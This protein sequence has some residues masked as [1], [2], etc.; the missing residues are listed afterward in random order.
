MLIKQYNPR[1]LKVI[2][3]ISLDL[4]SPLSTPHD[5]QSSTIIQKKYKWL[6][7]YTEQSLH[8]FETISHKEIVILHQEQIKAVK[9]ETQILQKYNL[10]TP[11][12]T[13]QTIDQY[14]TL[15][16]HE[17][18]Q[19]FYLIQDILTHIQ[20]QEALEQTYI[21]PPPQPSTSTSNSPQPTPNNPSTYKI[22]KQAIRNITWYT[23]EPIPKWALKEP[24][25]TPEY[26]KPT[27][28]QWQI[29]L[30]EDQADVMIVNGSRQ[31]GKSL[32]FKEN[33]LLYNNSYKKSKDLKIW[34]KIMSSNYTSQTITSLTYSKK[35]TYKITLENWIVHEVTGEHRIPT[36]KNFSPTQ[37]TSTNFDSN[38]TSKKENYQTAKQLYNHIFHSPNSKILNELKEKRRKNNSNR[39]NIQRRLQEKLQKEANIFV[40]TAFNYQNPNQTIPNDLKNITEQDIM[41]IWYFIWDWTR[42]KN[43][44]SWNHD[45]LLNLS[46]Q[47]YEITKRNDNW[48]CYQYNIH[49]FKQKIEQKFPDPDFLNSFNGYSYEK[50]ISPLIFTLPKEH[51]WKFLEWLF[52][53]DSYLSSQ[54]TNNKSKSPN[55]EYC[56]TS[57]E[58]IQQLQLFLLQMWIIN[59]TKTR[60]IKSNFKNHRTY[61]YYLYITDKQSLKTLVENID[62]TTKKNYSEF[63]QALQSTTTTNWKNSLIPLEAVKYITNTTKTKKKPSYPFQREKLENPSSSSSQPYFQWPNLKD[64]LK[65][66]WVKIESIEYNPTPQDVVTITVDSLDELY[67]SN[68]V[69]THNSFTIAEKAIEESFIPENDTLV[70]AF[71]AK[72]TNVIRNYILSLTRKFPEDTFIHYKSEWFIINTTSNTKIFFRTLA[73]WAENVLWLTLYNIIVDESQLIAD[74]IFEDALLPTLTTT[75]GRLMM[76]WTPWKKQKGYFF[77]TLIQAKKQ[78]HLTTPEIIKQKLDIISVYNVD[79]TQ[80]PLVHP[81]TRTKIMN[82]QHDPHIQRQYFCN[83]SANDDELFQP[84]TTNIYPISS[85][86]PN[87][88]STPSQTTSIPTNAYIVLWIDPAR[89]ADRSAYSLLYIYN[90]KITQIF[91]GEIPKSM[92]KKWKLQAIFY[93]KL[94]EK[95]ST[96][97]HQPTPNSQSSSPPQ[98]QSPNPKFISVIDATWVWDAVTEIFKENWFKIDITIRYTSGFSSSTDTQEWKVPKSTMI[99]TKLD[100]ISEWLFEV[101]KPWNKDY[102]EELEYIYEKELRNWQIAMEST[103][104]DDILNSSMIALFLIYTR[105]IL[106]RSLSTLDQQSKIPQTDDPTKWRMHDIENPH[107]KSPNPYLKS[108]NQSNRNQ[109]W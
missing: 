65:Y 6:I 53:T 13:E 58:L 76:I 94:K 97:L 21:S 63:Q 26:K 67:F 16:F 105:K 89:L 1:K 11:K 81:R 60:K 78:E 50:T 74:E 43:T 83:W 93:N 25:N 14:Q 5:Q 96:L 34:D 62:L 102:L 38:I 28:I 44:I 106:T 66:N 49:S 48:N 72:T 45:R 12:I 75:W 88:S 57:K 59:Q 23:H 18:S 9:K 71:L 107:S 85:Q 86:Q 42:N 36:S 10:I 41:L 103:F 46:P 17:P 68:W 47:Q 15:Y 24:Y 100:F 22:S 104:F 77:K 8:L 52:N 64:W 29:N 73:D 40:P 35:P 90:N 82:K 30:L 87:S 95:F 56:S 3:H 92:K 33:I 51:K 69:L 37:P 61:A 32:T 31:I 2:N 27:P 55:I 39:T 101:Y 109:N 4:N 99:N 84:P 98:P 19:L 54:T 70:W 91:S 108:S 80:N 7:Y 20:P 79:I